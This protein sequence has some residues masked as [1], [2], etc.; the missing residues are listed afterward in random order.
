M[1]L[2]V[3]SAL[4]L[5]PSS[6]CPSRSFPL[7][8]RT[9][10]PALA[11]DSCRTQ[12]LLL[13]A[14]LNPPSS[15][16]SCR[17]ATPCD[18]LLSMLQPCSTCPLQLLFS[19]LDSSAAAAPTCWLPSAL[20]TPHLPPGFTSVISIPDGTPGDAEQ[21]RRLQ[22]LKDFFFFRT[23]PATRLFCRITAP[24]LDTGGGGWWYPPAAF[25]SAVAD[26]A[27]AP[28]VCRRSN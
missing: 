17:S 9:E 14:V 25:P 16:S 28:L 8:S 5:Q 20:S 21:I 2:C 26:S 11:V 1:Q 27:S 12:C 6:T 15:R 10:A 3:P 23:R 4:R 22:V 13:T 7:P 24:A 18:Q 19:F